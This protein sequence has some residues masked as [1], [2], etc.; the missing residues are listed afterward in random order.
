[1]KSVTPV[2]ASSRNRTGTRVTPAESWPNA[3]RIAA[4]ASAMLMADRTCSALMIRSF[5]DRSSHSDNPADRLDQLGGVITHAIFDHGG[6]VPDVCRI[7]H[8]VA[9]D[10]HQVRQLP[11]RH[12][13][14]RIGFAQN[15][16]AIGAQDLHRLT[17]CE[18]SFDVQLVIALIPEPWKVATIGVHSGRQETPRLHERDLVLLRFV[19]QLKSGRVSGSRDVISHCEKLGFDLWIQSVQY[20]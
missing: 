19:K 20:A 3:S 18:S 14:Q 2:G 5:I 10:H 9:T 8:W 16:G 13:A 15:L 1:M 12:R 17:W 11:R 7:T 6:H 4:M